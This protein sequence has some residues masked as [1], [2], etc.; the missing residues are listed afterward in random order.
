[1]VE[2]KPHSITISWKL[3]STDTERFLIERREIKSGADGQVKTEW[4]P[5]VGADVQISGDT[6]TAHFRK[7][8]PGTFWNIRITGIDSKGQLGHQSNGFFRIETRP[9]GSFLPVWAWIVVA[10]VGAG[11][12]FWFLKNKVTFVRDDLDAR[13]SNL[14]K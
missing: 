5:W 12:A 8:P 7:L 2:S 11:S 10:L 14:E 6:A 3:T 4:K 9:V 1:L 13:I